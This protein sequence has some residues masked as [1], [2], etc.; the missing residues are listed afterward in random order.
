[1]PW[2]IC[3]DTEVPCSA[4][5]IV[6]GVKLPPTDRSNPPIPKGGMMGASKAV[7]HA[8]FCCAGV[9]MLTALV[10]PPPESYPCVLGSV[11]E[12]SG[13]P[14]FCWLAALG[15]TGANGWLG[16]S[17]QPTIAPEPPSSKI[18]VNSDFRID[19]PRPCS[20]AGCGRGQIATLLWSNARCRGAPS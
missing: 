1:M 17:V 2:H 3:G 16:P 7:D 6:N 8:A 12:A 13:P 11:V 19:N 4:I 14:L 18:P 5:S 15:P 9:Q 20:S 10:P